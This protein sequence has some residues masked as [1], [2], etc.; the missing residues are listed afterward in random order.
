MLI[1]S[2]KVFFCIKRL[3]YF[4]NLQDCSVKIL[5]QP[6][7][8]SLIDNNLFVTP[9]FSD[10]LPPLDSTLI[11]DF[12]DTVDHLVNLFD[13]LFTCLNLR[14]DIYSLGKFSEYVAEKLETSSVA[15]NRRNVSILFVEA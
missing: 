13:N 6:I 3:K 10:L 11:K 8:I 9:P 12:E 1:I 14:E 5:F 2:T 7:F 4:S 15:I